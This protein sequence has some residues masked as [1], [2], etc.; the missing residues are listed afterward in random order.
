MRIVVVGASGNAGVAVLRAL[1]A[2][3]QV[4]SVL[5]AARRPP[6]DWPAAKTAWR[7]LDI[8]ADP[9]ADVVHGADAVVHLAWLIQPGR[10]V[11]HCRA[12]NVDGTRRLLVAVAQASVPALVYASSVGAYS[13]GPKDRRVDETWPTGGIP[14]SFYSRH[15]VEVERM[16]DRFERERPQTRVVRLRPGLIFQ[17][18][19]ASEIRRLF[20][21][22][23]LPGPLVAPERIPVVPRHPR[24]RFQAVHAE[25]AAEAY[26]LAIVGDARGAFNVAADPVLDG[27]ELGRLLGARPVSVRARRPVDGHRPRSGAARLAAAA[28]RRRHPARAP[29]RPEQRGR[30]PDP[31]A[32]GRR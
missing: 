15:K 7:A 19:A 2:E 26:R 4:E 29:R 20:A 3:P 23:F 16:L 18:E 27:D 12:V 31:R 30:R 28:R 21:G 14:S 24:L 17:R 8:T 32:A 10:D 22:P 1:E 6:A 11:A 13:P 9:L 25:D 5:A